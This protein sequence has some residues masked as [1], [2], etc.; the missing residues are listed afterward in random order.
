MRA[1]VTGG[2][3][4]IGSHLIEQ[5]VNKGYDVIVID[6]LSTGNIRW[7]PLF[8]V[9]KFHQIDIS[10]TDE[11]RCLAAALLKEDKIDC[12]FHLAAK[13]SIVPSVKDPV[14]YNDTNARGTLN[15]LE[16]A[17]AIGVEKFIYAASGS[18]YG[19][20]KEIPT[21]ENCPIS[22]RYPYALTKNIGEQY[23]IMWGDLYKLPYVS[24]RLF[25]VFGPRMCLNGGYGGLFSTILP[26]KFNGK[27]LII[28]GDG[29]Q[30]RDFV[31][32]SDVV[33]AFLMVMEADVE[34][35]IFNVGMGTNVSVNQ[36]LDLLGFSRSN[37][38]R[39]PDRP[40]EPKQTLADITKIR[41]VLGWEPQIQFEDGL[42]IMLTDQ[43]YWKNAHV[44]TREESVRAQAEW[45][46]YFGQPLA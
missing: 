46:S 30:R 33:R 6:D 42:K 44:W 32:V 31:Y 23:I 9:V 45:Y 5:L 19:I 38:I 28:I 34:N 20:P 35:K 29:E 17:R 13:A 14:S 16:L 43:G 4:F 40:G 39:L 27:P 24:L 21:T 18:C 41:S 25:N 11:V 12:L 2:S 37:V 8:G 10:N 36:I 1:I 3:G 26:Q 7:L 22:P 15:M